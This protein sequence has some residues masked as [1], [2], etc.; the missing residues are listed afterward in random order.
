MQTEQANPSSAS[1]HFAPVLEWSPF[2]PLSRKQF[3]QKMR[4]RHSRLGFVPATPGSLLRSLVFPNKPL[5]SA[6]EVVQTF[7][8]DAFLF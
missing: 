1:K 5:L 4:K 8:E 6:S 2:S 7:H 3:V